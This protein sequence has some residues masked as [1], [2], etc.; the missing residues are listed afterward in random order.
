MILLDPLDEFLS[1]F[2]FDENNQ[3][4]DLRSWR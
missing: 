4:L 3:L 2:A 1:L